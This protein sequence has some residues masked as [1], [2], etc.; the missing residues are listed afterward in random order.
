MTKCIH[1]IADIGSVDSEHRSI[2]SIIRFSLTASS[3]SRTG[4]ALVSAHAALIG[5]EWARHVDLP[6]VARAP[7]DPHLAKRRTGLVRTPQ[8]VV[9]C[10]LVGACCDLFQRLDDRGACRLLSNHCP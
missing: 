2:Q 5:P 7:G 8:T 9:G 3:D 1:G 6:R 10:V 4:A